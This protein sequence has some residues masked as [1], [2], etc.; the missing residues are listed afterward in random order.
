[1]SADK[2]HGRRVLIYFVLFFAL[3]AAVNAVFIYTAL[4]THSG[5]VTENPY[6]KGLAYNKTLSA[7]REQPHLKEQAMFDAPFFQWQIKDENGKPLSGAKTSVNFFRPVK[8]G[9]DFDM[10]LTETSPGIYQ[11]HP[12]FPEKGLWVAHLDATWNGKNYRTAH[13]L[14]VK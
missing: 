14:I 5:T 10:Q 9:K 8:D 11:A 4:H 7:S 12:E 1:M 2:N 13:N 3:I 6:E